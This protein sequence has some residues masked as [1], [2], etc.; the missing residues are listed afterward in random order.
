MTNWNEGFIN[1]KVHHIGGLWTWIQFENAEA[2]MEFKANATLRQVFASIKPILKNFIMDERVIWI[3]VNGL[4]LCAWCSAVLKKVARLVRTFMFFEVD[5]A[6]NMSIGRMCIATK[7]MRHIDEQVTVV[8][9]GE[10]FDV[11]ISELA[12]WNIKIED[13][14]ETENENGMRD[15]EERQNTDDF[16]DLNV[17]EEVDIGIDV[18][19]KSRCYP[20]DVYPVFVDPESSTQ[21]DGAQSSRVPVP[22]SKDP[23]E[24]NRQACLVGTDTVSEPFEEGS[25]TSGT[26][27]TSSD[28]I[29]PL[30]PDHPLTHTTPILVPIIHRT[31]RMAVRVPL[32]MSPSLSAGIAE[33]TAM[34]DPAFRKRFRSSY[35]SLPSPTLPVRKSEEDEEVEESLDSDSESEDVEDDG[36]TTEDE[37]PGAKDE[38]LVARVEGPGFDDESY[39]LDDESHVEDGKI[40]GLDDESPCIDDEGCDIE[41]DEL[42]LREEDAVPEG[43]QRAVS[44][45]RT[46]MSEPLRLGYGALRHREL[47]LEDDH[48]YST[49]EVGQGFVS[50]PEP[51]RSERVSAFRQ[52]TLTTWTDPED[53]MIY[54]YVPV[55]LLPAPPVQTPP[56][57][58][59]MLALEAWAGRVDTWMIDMSQAGYDD[60]RLVLDM[61]LQQTALQRELQEIKDRVTMLEQERDRRKQ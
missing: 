4:P 1:L 16:M 29:A 30:L 28:S 53:G 3:E 56:S 20:R 25:G 51:E 12:T 5:Q 34:S 31:A 18:T 40:Y 14:H 61:L 21:A 44:V 10:H 24:A 47:A 55:Y 57:P 27:S 52:P 26:R 48:V 45:V 37:D 42:G 22:L 39:G 36:P 33:V 8:I 7:H 9:N 60:H 59:P 2:C 38:G 32:M 54:I 23:Y 41:S 13:D 6:Q 49:F 19:I 35:N 43:Q 50:A 46:S 11:H 15:N 58:E 17:H